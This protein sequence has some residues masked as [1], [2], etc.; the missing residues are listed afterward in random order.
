M[1]SL[2]RFG[3]RKKTVTSIRA[4]WALLRTAFSGGRRGR[5]HD[6]VAEW[7]RTPPVLLRVV[8]TNHPV[9]PIAR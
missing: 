1:D 3:R 9:R 4:W 6:L 7:A 2:V 5:L 8:W